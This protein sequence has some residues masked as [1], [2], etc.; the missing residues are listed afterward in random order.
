MAARAQ[1]PFDGVWL[2]APATVLE[3]RV[4][5]RKGDAS[6]ATVAVLRQQLARD[7]GP[8][9]WRTVDASETDSASRA[10]AAK[11]PGD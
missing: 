11:P 5:A 4:A 3:A 2:T 10:I 9:T 1:V 6:D 7:P 8:M